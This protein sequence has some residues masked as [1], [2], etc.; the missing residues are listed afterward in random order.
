VKR[1]GGVTEKDLLEGAAERSAPGVA[2]IE[3]P[4]AL[5]YNGISHVVTMATPSNLEEMA[6]GFSLSEGILEKA[7]QLFD[8]E[9]I[10][11]DLGLEINM[12]ISAEAFANLKQRRRNLVGRTGCG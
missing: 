5:V 3:T 12:A 7:E 11:R 6:L 9:L 2:A 1:A 10:Q 8:C 4:V